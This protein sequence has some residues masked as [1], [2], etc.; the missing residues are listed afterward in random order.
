MEDKKTEHT[1]EM[2]IFFPRLPDKATNMFKVVFTGT[3]PNLT[4]M[5]DELIIRG[6]TVSTRMVKSNV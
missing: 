3:Y 6:C 2:E 4:R 1:W 5:C